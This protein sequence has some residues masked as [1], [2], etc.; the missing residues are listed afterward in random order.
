[1]TANGSLEFTEWQPTTLPQSEAREVRSAVTSLAGTLR[2]RISQFVTTSDG[3]VIIRNLIGSTA[4][5][6]GGTVRVEPRHKAD[7]RWT[8]A[9]SQLLTPQTRISV[10]GSER[11]S[12]TPQ[13]N[14]LVTAVATEYANRLEAALAS[15]GPLEA[16]QREQITSNRLRGHLQVSRWVRTSL[17]K[18]TRFPVERDSFTTSN[19]FTRAMSKVAAILAVSARSGAVGSRLRNIERAL[20]PG[21]PSPAFVDPAVSGR[22]LPAQ[23][24]NYQPAWDIAAAI[25]KNRSIV[26]NPGTINGLE[27]AV[28]SWPLLETL[29]ERVLQTVE[30]DGRNGYHF[31]PKS[32]YPLLTKPRSSSL[33]QAVE[34]DGLL[35]KN[36][37]PAVSFEA[38]YTTRT[39]KP[40]RDHAFQTLATAG[41]LGTSI[42]IL[43]YPGAEPPQVYEVGGSDGPR[44]LA[45]IGLSMFSYQRGR[46]DRDRAVQMEALIGDVQRRIATTAAA[47]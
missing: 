41:A 30:R 20:L 23:W 6:A 11:S 17:L 3:Q 31:E 44:F 22:N 46:G 25:L 28:E 34:P 43:V 24:R 8:E 14:D 33:I 18:P 15:D 10:S 39:S 7:D 32:R 4:L 27:V 1:M 12:F 38:K 40:D 2:P 13:R 5:P 16:Y 37:L 21:S 29:L 45:T 35:T 42:A 36:A 19:D 26:G 47:K 9:V